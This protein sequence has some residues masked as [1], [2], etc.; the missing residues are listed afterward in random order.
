MINPSLHI[1]KV[2]REKVEKSLIDTFNKNKMET[3]RDVMKNKY[4]CGI[5]LIMFYEST[6]TKTK[7]L[8]M[9]FSCVLY[10]IIYNY[11]CIDYLYCKYKNLTIITSNRI[12]EQ[13][14]FNILLGIVIAEVL[15]NL[16]SCHGFKEKPNSTIILNC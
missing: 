10:S 14:I 1:N 3:I 16:V 8:V 13:T 15:L 9:V 4:T 7:I 11:V 6:G 12:S 2:F 5:V